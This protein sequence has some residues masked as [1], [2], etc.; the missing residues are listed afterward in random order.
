M[1]WISDPSRHIRL[2]IFPLPE[3][4]RSRQSTLIHITEWGMLN[5]TFYTGRWPVIQRDLEQH[6]LNPNC[7]NSLRQ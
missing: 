3:I 6:N 1:G 7:D 2:S 5:A 4:I